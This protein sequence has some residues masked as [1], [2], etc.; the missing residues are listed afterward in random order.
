MYFL[1]KLLLAAKARL[2]DGERKV[3]KWLVTETGILRWRKNKE[4]SA[5]SV[6]R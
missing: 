5:G 3:N 1:D 4:N 6:N 2:A